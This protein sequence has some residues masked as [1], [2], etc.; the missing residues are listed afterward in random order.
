MGVGVVH[1]HKVYRVT[2]GERGRL[3]I[4]RSLTLQ[5]SFILLDEP[6]SG[7][8]PLTVKVLEELIQDLAKS[9]IG[10]LITDK[11]V[12]ETL[13]GTDLAYILK[14]RKIFRKGRPDALNYHAEDRRAY[15]R[16][17]FS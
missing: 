14:S 5:P 12:R 2:G 3:E 4:A 1:T 16:V 17:H 6:F 13:S 10:V 15:S 9:G 7:I 8:D 11:N